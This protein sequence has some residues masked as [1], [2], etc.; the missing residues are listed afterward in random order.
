[1]RIIGGRIWSTNRKT[2]KPF[3]SKSGSGIIRSPLQNTNNLSDKEQIQ[4]EKN[5]ADQIEQ[6][7]R[8]ADQRALR[9][10][11]GKKSQ[12]SPSDIVWNKEEK[13]VIKKTAQD[14]ERTKEILKK[15]TINQGDE[16]PEEKM[17]IA[18]ENV[19]EDMLSQ[20]KP[21]KFDS[22]KLMSFK[23][24]LKQYLVGNKEQISKFARGKA[25]DPQGWQRY[26]KTHKIATYGKPKEE[27]TQDIDG[28]N[29]KGYV[30][31]I[32]DEQLWIP[33]DFTPKVLKNVKQMGLSGNYKEKGTYMEKPDIP[34][35]ERATHNPYAKFDAD[36]SYHQDFDIYTL[37]SRYLSGNEPP[38]WD[39]SGLRPNQKGELIKEL[40]LLNAELK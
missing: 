37:A 12:G 35:S 40:V 23:D 4:R 22:Y 30:F 25:N 26:W 36:A 8:V 39:L 10:V 15:A 32:G 14:P 28:E 33:Q 2:K 38:N 9:L 13:E 6:M 29:V 34:A 24:E 17:R 5:I 7:Q 16:T 19:L 11:L 3:K 1:M 18:E 27:M 21:S 20:N 31:Q